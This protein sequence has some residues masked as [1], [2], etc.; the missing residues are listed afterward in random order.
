[1]QCCMPSCGFEI[2]YHHCQ[3]VEIELV[4]VPNIFAVEIRQRA[5]RIDGKQKLICLIAVVE[6]CTSGRDSKEVTQQI[7][8]VVALMFG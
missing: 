6:R 5:E 7:L 1:M 3:I 2:K 4:S 8:A